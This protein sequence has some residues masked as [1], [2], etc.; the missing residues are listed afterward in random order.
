M[1]SIFSTSSG[2]RPSTRDASHLK[3]KAENA[4]DL[5]TEIIVAAEVYYGDYGDTLTIEDNVMIAQTHLNEAGTNC[6]IQ[7]VVVDKGYHSEETL[8]RLQKES[9][10]RTYI[11]E[12]DQRPIVVEEQAPTPASCVS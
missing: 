10:W 6:E 5:Y 12:P 8:D 11:P 1:P 4:V 3:Y 7:E 2:I 9:P